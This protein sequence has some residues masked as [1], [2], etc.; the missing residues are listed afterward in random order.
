[1]APRRGCIPPNDVIVCNGQ[2]R[3]ASN[4]NVTGGFEAGGVTVLA[5]YPKQPFDFAGRTGTV[6]FDVS[7]DTHGTHAA[8]PEFWVTDLPI[9]APFTHFGS[10]IGESEEWLR[11]PVRGRGAAGAI[12][13]CPNGNNLNVPRWTVDSAVV[14]RNYVMEDTAGFGTPGQHGGDAAGLCDCPGRGRGDESRGGARQPESDRRVCERCGDDDAAQTSRGDHECQFGVDAG[15]DLAGRR[16]L[17]C[18]QRR[19]PVAARAYVRL[20]QRGV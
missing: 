10:W 6:A 17:Q 13:A 15:P 1:M 14:I 4:D 3:E 9:P 20:G 18:G 5:M 11:D 2:L 19:P 8:W 7:N 12:R 16:P